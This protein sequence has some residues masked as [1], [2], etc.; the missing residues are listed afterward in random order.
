[1][2]V[3]SVGLLGLYRVNGG[4]KWQ[5]DIGTPYVSLVAGDDFVV[6]SRM[7][8]GVEC[9]DALDGRLRWTRPAERGPVQLAA[10]RAVWVG[11]E[12]RVM[13]LYAT[14][15]VVR[16][17]CEVPWAPS[18]LA[19]LGGQVYI[20]GSEGYAAWTDGSLPLWTNSIRSATGVR[21]TVYAGRAFAGGSDGSLHCF[22]AATGANR[23]SVQGGKGRCTAPRPRPAWRTALRPK[24]KRWSPSM[25]RRAKSSGGETSPT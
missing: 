14:S 8:G 15:G 11:E 16:R 1:M 12:G 17:E 2:A 18:G 23:W 7:D 21:P 6:G 25:S 4:R 10:G 9:R 24:A 20:S 13:E 3:A 5:Q 22:D 19:E